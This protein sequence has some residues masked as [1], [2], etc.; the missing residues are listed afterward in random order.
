MV[1]MD[2]DLFVNFSG[3]APVTPEGILCVE[4][5]LG[6]ALPDDYRQFLRQKNGGEG[7]IG[8]NSYL[9]LWPLEQLVSL[10]LAYEAA[11]Y[12]PGFLLFGSNGGG[13]AYAFNSGL[14]PM[15]IVA[16]PFVGMDPTVS[17]PIA[18]GFAGFLQ[19]LFAS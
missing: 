14:R 15:P 6:Y 11:R 4:K 10:N 18:V 1:K 5:E 2:A 19:K 12:A 13:E 17:Q 7:F 16:M 8:P 3:G 9:I